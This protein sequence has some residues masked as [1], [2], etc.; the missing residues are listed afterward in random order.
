M[1]IPGLDMFRLFLERIYFK[2]NP[3]KGDN[4]HLHHI[5]LKKLGFKRCT[6]LIQSVIFLTILF[7]LFYSLKFGIIFSLI[8]YLVI[9]YM[10]K[11]KKH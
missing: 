1:C 3:F 8:S 4:N 5:L 10:Y 11:Y 7:G 6:I 2:K 9:I